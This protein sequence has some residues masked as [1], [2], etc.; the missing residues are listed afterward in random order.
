MVERVDPP[1]TIE[2]V[3][4]ETPAFIYDENLLTAAVTRVARTAATTGCRLL[5]T[6]KPFSIADALRLL[7]GHVAGFA[8]SSVFEAEL[9]REVLGPRGSVHLTAPGLRAQDLP[10]VNQFCDHVSFNSLSQLAR[11]GPELDSGISRGLRVNPQ[12]SFVTDPRYDP[13]RIAS[14]LGTPLGELARTFETSP[15]LL[16]GLDGLHFHSNCDS[17]DLGQLRQ[18]VE[19]LQSS[20]DP[21]LFGS[22][23]WL[24]MGGGYLFASDQQEDELCGAVERA[25]SVHG[26]EIF[27]EPGAALVRDAGFF[28]STVVDLFASDGH[29]IAVLDTTVNHMPEVYEYQFEPEVLGHTEHGEFE[30]TLAGCSCLAGDIFGHYAF[31][32]ELAVGSTIVFGSSG[33]Y[34]MVKAHMFNGINLPTVYARTPSGEVVLKKR[35]AYE[36]FTS[37]CGVTTT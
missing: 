16:A 10:D 3:G 22:I 20:L 15:E 14:R 1:R 5:Y 30:Y 29:T 31:D 13:C 26:L 7:A 37:R 33:A 25:R 27:I 23:R 18:T 6:L 4:I 28:V 8:A 21:R 36:D 35:F 32:H 34:T 2:W 24:N 11:L 19:H 17:D 9:A 12:L